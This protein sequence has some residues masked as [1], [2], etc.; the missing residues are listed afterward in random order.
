MSPQADTAPAPARTRAR[1]RVE[2]IEPI[3]CSVCGSAEW[4]A[5]APGTSTDATS[6]PTSNVVEIVPA[7]EVPTQAWCAEHWR[8][9]WTRVLA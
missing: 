9:S 1:S 7:E 2:S 3:V 5:V 6:W 4:I 8:Q